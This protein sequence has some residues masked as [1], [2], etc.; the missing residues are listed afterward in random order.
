VSTLTRRRRLGEFADRK[1]LVIGSHFV[2][3][4]AGRVVRDGEAFRFVVY[5]QGS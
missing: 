5:P 3:P 1:L 2:A 4:A